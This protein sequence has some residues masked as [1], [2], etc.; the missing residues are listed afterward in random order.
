MKYP[1]GYLKR[2]MNVNNNQDF[3][4]IVDKLKKNKDA[5][6]RE[7]LAKFLR[8]I[9]NEH[10]LEVLK[11]LVA[12]RNYLVQIE[13]IESLY[14]FPYEKAA[15]VVLDQ[16]HSRHPL[17]R[18][19]V[20]EYICDMCSD[21]EE[22]KRILLTV[23]ETH[24]WAKIHLLICQAVLTGNHQVKQLVTMYGKCSYLNQTTMLNS[25]NYYY[26]LLNTDDQKIIKCFV[27]KQEGKSRP[28]AVEEAF[29]RLT[30][31]ISVDQHCS[32]QTFL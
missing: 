30:K 19:Y 14:A 7:D 17:V 18:G 26:D 27:Q 4:S 16:I 20:Y 5:F 8:Y 21:R 31:H 22:A 28:V 10:S 6:V 29:A 25:F 24:T 3:A 11:E 23:N 13:A 2:N 9:N 1:I 12:D 15:D 32:S